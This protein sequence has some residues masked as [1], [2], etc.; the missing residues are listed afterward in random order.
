MTTEEDW[1]NLTTEIDLITQDPS[2]L[3][4]MWVSATEGDKYE[5]LARLDH[6]PETEVVNN[7]TRR[8]EAEETVWRDFYTGQRLADNW[9][10]PYAESTEDTTCLH[11]HWQPAVSPSAFCVFFQISFDFVVLIIKIG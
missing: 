1:E 4:W 7:E 3:P 6:W 8:L 11:C 2:I 9:T 5:K 10:K